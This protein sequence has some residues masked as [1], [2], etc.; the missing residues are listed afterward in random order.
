MNVDSRIAEQ[1]MRVRSTFE[2]RLVGPD[3]EML[4]VSKSLRI[5]GRP[6]EHLYHGAI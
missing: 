1:P 3:L 4:S 2:R 5:N 6:R